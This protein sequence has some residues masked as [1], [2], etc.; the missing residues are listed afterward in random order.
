[1][2]S[3]V[4]DCWFFTIN[5][6]GFL[7]LSLPT[8]NLPVSQ[9]SPT[10]DFLSAQGLTSHTV[11]WH[12]FFC[13]TSVFVVSYFLVLLFFWLSTV[14]WAEFFMRFWKTIN[15]SYTCNIIFIFT[16]RRLAKRGICRRRVSVCLSVHLCVCVSVT[17]RYCIKTAKRRITQITPYDSPITLVFWHQSSLRNSKGITPC[18]G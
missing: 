17:L 15:V 13:A 12:S 9:I 11:T 18:G 4:V 5:I 6:Y 8:Q 7:A 14:D 2:F 10:V 1:M 3:S 16:V